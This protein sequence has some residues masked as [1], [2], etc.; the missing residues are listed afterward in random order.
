M[1][2]NTFKN[3]ETKMLEWLISLLSLKTLT[4]SN[5]RDKIES[6]IIV[7]FNFFVLSITYLNIF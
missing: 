4:D 7:L 5:L 6:T 1:H 3:I 2:K